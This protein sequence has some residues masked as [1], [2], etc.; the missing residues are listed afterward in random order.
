MTV[1]Q[2]ATIERHAAAGGA[3]SSATSVDQGR[4]VRGGYY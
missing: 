1:A 4:P 3:A 2:W